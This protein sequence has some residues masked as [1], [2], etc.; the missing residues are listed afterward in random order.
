[1]GISSKARTGVISLLFTPACV[2]KK[3]IIYNMTNY[4]T[5]Y[6]NEGLIWFSLT[7]LPIQVGS[8]HFWDITPGQVL[9]FYAVHIN[10]ALEVGLATQNFNMKYSKQGNLAETLDSLTDVLLKQGDKF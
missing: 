8:S 9:T 6:V 10:N 1:M 7:W 5:A 3:T 4:V 2:E